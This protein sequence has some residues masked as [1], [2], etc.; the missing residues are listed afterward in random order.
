MMFK[1]STIT[2]LDEAEQI[3]NNYGL[4]VIALEL[5]I[6]GKTEDFRIGV[7]DGQAKLADIVPLARILSTKL[8]ILLLDRL[9]KSRKSVP[10]CKGCSACCSYLIPLSV[11]EAFRLRQELLALSVEHGTGILQ[12]YFD[13]SKAVLDKKPWKFDINKSAKND[14]SRISRLNK[15][16]SAFKLPCPF[17]SDGLCTLY[18]QRAI[19]CREHIVTGSP[20]LCEDGETNNPNVVSM[21]V[22]VLEALGKL[23]AELEQSEVEAVM[24]PLAMP[25]AQDNLKRSER[26]WS[27]VMMVERFAEILKEMS[28]KNSTKAI[29]AA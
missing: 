20:A 25:W 26:T 24:L 5:D 9:N 17:L 14:L 13:A 22:S 4:E 21:P 1:E 12:S 29:H 19:A 8:V 7:A 6:L 23:T 27:A 10:C 16:Y 11:P 28:S 18:D 2:V 15:W 3:N